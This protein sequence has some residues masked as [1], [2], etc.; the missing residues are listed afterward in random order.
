MINA[1]LA[2]KSHPNHQTIVKLSEKVAFGAEE[3]VIIGGPCTVDQNSN[4]GQSN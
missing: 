2:V 4:G 1:K 3:L